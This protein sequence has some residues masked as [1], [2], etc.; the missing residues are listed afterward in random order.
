[1]QTIW[2]YLVVDTRLSMLMPGMYPCIPGW[3][4]D[5]F[6]RPAGIPDLAAAPDAEHLITVLGGC[7]RT[8]FVT[9]EI[10]TTLEPST[11][12]YAKLHLEIEAK[13]PKTAQIE[14]GDWWRLSQLSP[15]RGEPATEAGWRYFFR[16]TGSNHHTPKNEL[17]TQTQVYLT[18]PFAGW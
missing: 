12:F 13:N 7:S 1:M 9:Q 16:M 17:R 11:D 8:R 6:Y 18:A 4:C 15:H 2:Q 14:P 10:E 3:H 5:E